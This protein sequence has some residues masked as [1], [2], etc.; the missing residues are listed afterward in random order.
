MN[1]FNDTLNAQKVWDD[2]YDEVRESSSISSQRYVRLNPELPTDWVKIDN[3]RHMDELRLHVKG[4]LRSPKWQEEVKSVSHR[5]IASSFFFEE[6]RMLAYG[7][8]DVVE[9]AK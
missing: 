5:L 4:V 9:G 8:E 6:I 1:S 7:N 3:I 2:F